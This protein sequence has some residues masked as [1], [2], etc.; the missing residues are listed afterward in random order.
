MSVMG[1]REG[2]GDMHDVFVPFLQVHS[3]WRYSFSLAIVSS[4]TSEN[5]FDNFSERRDEG[6][7]YR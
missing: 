1:K 4:N 3:V 6:L 7:V 2:S 5:D